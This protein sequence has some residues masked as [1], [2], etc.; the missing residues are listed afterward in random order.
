MPTRSQARKAKE[1]KKEG[2]KQQLKENVGSLNEVRADLDAY[3][4]AIKKND[5]AKCKKLLLKIKLAILDFNLTPPL[6]DEETVVAAQLSL[7]REALEFA[8]LHA[9]QEKDVKAFERNFVQVK[10]YYTD[11]GSLLEES[12]RKWQLIAL[13]LLC[14]LAHNRIAE[15]HTELELVSSKIRQEN[16][17]IKYPIA[18]EQRLME[19]NYNQVLRMR[20]MLPMPQYS[21]F[22]DM[23]AETVRE[24]ISECAEHAYESIPLDDAQEMLLLDD[25]AALE[26]HIAAR[27][28]STEA[29]A[30]V[31]KTT[32][33]DERNV[34]DGAHR[35]I[36]QSL[37]Y[38]TELERIV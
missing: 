8:T 21:F 30:I 22:T 9:V 14:L 12:E 6:K 4:E 11:Y 17:Y 34:K 32:G 16:M 7:A 5:S 24:K 26:K 33:D 28:W 23:L 18:L 35:L 15:F 27:G 3:K 20:K 1:A 31:F 38:A 10:T 29:G 25:K 36:E 2:K 19:G 37:R 13:N